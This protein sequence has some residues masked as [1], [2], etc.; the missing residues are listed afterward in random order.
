MFSKTSEKMC[1]KIQKLDSENFL[2]APGLA[3][4]ATLKKTEVKLELLT[5]IHML[6]RVEKGIRRGVCHAIYQY[7]KAN[8]KDMKDYDKNKESSYLKYWDVNNLYG[9]AMWQKLPINKF[10]WI[11]DT[12]PL[13]KD[14]EKTIMKKL[15]KDIFSKLIFNILKYC[16]N[17]IMIYHFYLKE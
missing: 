6:L 2:P 10:E 1:L 14:L 11:E 16:I 3:W 8:N 4:Y 17:F 7:A 9:W 12:S 13:N 15:I 5:N